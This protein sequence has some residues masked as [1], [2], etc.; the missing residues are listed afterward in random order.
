MELLCSLT[1]ICKENHLQP[2]ILEFFRI[3]FSSRPFPLL[4]FLIFCWKPGQHNKG[5]GKQSPWKRSATQTYH[6]RD[7]AIQHIEYLST[8]KVSSMLLPAA[9]F[10][11]AVR[12]LS[13]LPLNFGKYFLCSLALLFLRYCLDGRGRGGRLYMRT[14]I[15]FPLLIERRSL[16][17]I[18]RFGFTSTFLLSITLGM[19]DRFFPHG[20]AHFPLSPCCS[21][22]PPPLYSSMLLFGPLTWGVRHG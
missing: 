2:L 5:K 12:L 14:P 21:P 10:G 7:I 22:P 1:R 13:N 8:A 15:V 18:I 17:S 11:V 20:I 9:P 16:S 19:N 4:Q 3:N 6:P